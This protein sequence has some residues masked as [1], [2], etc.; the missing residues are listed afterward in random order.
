MK[1]L[2]NKNHLKLKK[3]KNNALILLFLI[4]SQLTFAQNIIS[5]SGTITFTN[6]NKME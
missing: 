3:M 2:R 6:A 4:L 1:I 5:K